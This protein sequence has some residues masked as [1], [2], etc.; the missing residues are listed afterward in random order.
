MGPGRGE[1]KSVSKNAEFEKSIGLNGHGVGW[2]LPKVA[3]V[4]RW[5]TGLGRGS[6]T[7][8]RFCEVPMGSKHSIH[9]CEGTRFA[10]EGNFWLRRLWIGVLT[11]ALAV[12][13][14]S[15]ESVGAG[16]ALSGVSSR[17]A[18]LWSLRPL[19]TALVPPGSASEHPI[20]RF[21]DES[22]ASHG[23]HRAAEAERRTLIR[24]VAWDLTGLPPSLS[25]VAGYLSDGSPDAFER[26]V[27]RYLASPAYGERWGRWWL[28]LARYADTNG[29]DENKVMAN[30][31]RYR[32][33]VIRSFNSNQPYDA[34]VREQVAGDLLDRTG[35]P[36]SIVFDRWMATGFL[37]LGPKMLA[38]QDKPKLV[39][40]LVDEQIDVVSRAFLGL[41]MSCARCHDHKFDPISA[42]D[43]YALAGILR[44]TKTLE[45]LAFVSKFNERRITGSERMMAIEAHQASLARV[46][47]E[48]DDILRGAN[49]GLLGKW[50]ATLAQELSLWMDSSRTVPTNSLEGRWKHWWQGDAVSPGV[51]RTLE[52]LAKD[53]S[54]RTAWLSSM[55]AGRNS[56]A[57][58]MQL[59]PGR[60]GLGFQ[61][62]GKNHLDSPSRPELEPKQW[63]LQTWVYAEEFAKDGDPRRWLVAKNDNE[64]SEGH[65]AL[66]LDGRHPMAYLNIGGGP[67]H[68]ISVRASQA[69]R[70]KQWHQLVATYDGQTLAVFVDGKPAGQSLVGKSRVAGSGR[71]SI[72]RRPD[73]H[74]H[75]QGRLDEVIVAAEVWTPERVREAFETPEHVRD[76]PAVA[77]WD[78]DHLSDQERREAD[79]AEAR[80]AVFGAG[81]VLALPKDPKPL[82]S[83][84]DR[85][86]LAEKE[87]E[88]EALKRR[89]P[90]APEFALAVEEGAV[91]DLPVHIRGS[92]LQ[93]AAH[94]VPRGFPKAIRVGHSPVIPASQSGR[95]ELAQWLTQPDHPLTSRVLVNRVWQT[96]F[97]SG[98][99]RSSDN[100]GLRGDRPTH[101][102]LLDW[103]ARGFVDSGWNLKQLH[104]QIL[105]S[106]TWRQRGPLLADPQGFERDPENKWLWHFPR[107]RLEAEMIRDGVLAVAGRLEPAM[108]GSLVA[109]KN[110]E[111]TPEDDVSERSRRRTLYLPVVRDRVYDL[112]TLFDF[113]NPSVGVSRRTP[114]VVSHQAL[115]WMNSPW[116]KEQSRAL[117]SDLRAGPGLPS[118]DLVRLAYERVLGRPPTE[119][120]QARS[121]QFLSTPG[122][123][124][125]TPDSLERWASWCQV[126]L[127][128][129]EFQYR[130]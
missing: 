101:P 89:D 27:D 15:E 107:Q 54:A 122:I 61:A 83:D 110:D 113:A 68:V 60:V 66:V 52:A 92:H 88:R 43:Y 22:L 25:E 28:D 70:K 16:A 97:G 58:E 74:V 42:Q 98:L 57:P 30:A 80:E 49:A 126:L 90:G 46:G 38:E 111:Y 65:Y 108:G 115:F 123:T 73:N 33:W 82:Y 119:A 69:L 125:A 99:V 117:A 71:L 75:F 45:N 37:V 12:K 51:R 112:L 130:H 62:N 50:Q 14:L 47:K 91:V 19:G 17:A 24:R 93:L 85:R 59:A 1:S 129:S 105:T 64:W 9:C 13:V 86:A 77:R 121:I 81:G 96:H 3:V 5:E 78:F 118:G 87:Q 18:A 48:Y 109:W 76:W 34:F 36:D 94:P 23:L 128:S 32:D 44:S 63:T 102:E 11:V 4:A 84:A 114:T 7:V 95:L 39:M 21:I 53:S 31:W 6:R 79:W 106:A 35:V 20:D 56:V 67:E 41:T 8:A 26:M 10:P 29:Q 127:A 103:L 2:R 104:R 100:F 124:A 40:D 55:D 116:V 72:G 120:E